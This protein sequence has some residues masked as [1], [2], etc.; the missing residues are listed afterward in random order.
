[1]SAKDVGA[2][3]RPAKNAVI[4]YFAIAAGVS[5]EIMPY[6]NRQGCFCAQP[7]VVGA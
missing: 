2:T 6:V 3:G 5:N 1:M 7:T 4:K